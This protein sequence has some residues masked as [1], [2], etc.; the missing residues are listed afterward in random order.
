[1]R[2]KNAF[3]VL[4]HSYNA[5][6]RSFVAVVLMG[7]MVG[8]LSVPS[9]WFTAK[10]VDALSERNQDYKIIIIYGLLA[11]LFAFLPRV[12]ELGTEFVSFKHQLA[13]RKRLSAYMLGLTNKPRF[14]DHLDDPT[15]LDRLQLARSV[16]SAVPITVTFFIP[17]LFSCI[18]TIAG[19]SAVI[20]IV[21]PPLLFL[22]LSLAVPTVLIQRRLAAKRAL[23]SMQD[24]TCFRWLAYFEELFQTPASAREIRRFGALT[25]FEQKYKQSLDESNARQLG[26]QRQQ[27]RIELAYG[28]FM[29]LLVSIALAYVC[30]SIAS[31]GLNAGD[32]VLVAAA[33]VAIN[34][35][36]SS[37]SEGIGDVLEGAA[38]FALVESLEN[39]PS[40]ESKPLNLVEAGCDSPHSKDILEIRDL[41]FSYNGSP[42]KTLCRV[43]LT[44]RRGEK[45]A[46]VG[47]N[48]SGKSTLIKL[49]SGA[50]SN[51]DGQIIYQ[52]KELHEVSDLPLS[53]LFQDFTRYEMTLLDNIV[54]GQKFSSEALDRVIQQSGL[55]SLVASL[56]SGINTMLTPHHFDEAGGVGISLSGGQ[57]QRVAT[58][59]CLLHSS[60]DLLVL[61]EPGTGLDAHAELELYNMLVSQVDP[62]KGVVFV[63]H[64]MG[65]LSRMDRVVYMVSGEIV[66][67]G[68]HDELMDRCESYRLL[69]ESYNEIHG[70]GV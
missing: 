66:A 40:L 29:A 34:A 57:W 31:R 44:V 4:K 24:T 36:I 70:V 37:T 43:N 52:S 25:F 23:V 45:I 17:Q 56:P 19:F 22:L 62:S 64:Q 27:L 38:Q 32:F 47:E 12:M 48:G 68:C 49:M 10:V 53:C 69:C 46:L 39:H 65:I 41:E 33:A 50:Y 30:Y 51:Y 42:A 11:G 20:Y 6:R 67:Q 15:V 9:A 55:S 35:S 13:V 58:A 16:L 2:V 3:T 8:L 61:D 59:R 18:G 7:S 63:T 28:L 54:L 1:M 5:S 14:T 21:W 26:Q 60:K